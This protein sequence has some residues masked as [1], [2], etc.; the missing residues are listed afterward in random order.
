[1]RFSLRLNNDLAPDEFCTLAEVAEER[2]FD[3]LWVSND[4]FLH[5]ASVLLTAA[6][7]RT[8]TLSLGC[9]I[10]NPYTIHP[11]ELAMTAA[12]LQDVS[13]G[14]FLLGLAAGAGQFLE[15]VGITQHRPLGTTRAAIES[16]R[17]LTTGKPAEQDG[18]T[19]QAYLRI[20]SEG[21]PIY[22]GAM[23][24]KMLELAG[25]CAD[26]ALPLLYPPEHFP[27]ARDHIAVGLERGGRD[28]SSFD[29]PACIW[30]SVDTDRTAARDA[31]AAKIA[32][33]ASA[34]SP[35]LLA[36]AGLAPEDFSDIDAALAAHDPARAQSLV[37]ERMLRLGIAGDVDD[38][39]ARCRWLL[40]QGATH[41]SFGPPLGP[42]PRRAIELLG[43]EVLPALRD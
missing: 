2:G 38:V 35:Y 23:S 7:V 40:E 41:I 25:E 19:E 12:T 33:Y 5:S 34:F 31:L 21:V 27:T 15:W 29:L 1:M 39:V 26:G 6:A 9:G 42:D 3:Q 16:I 11:A 4:L 20:A 8:S 17:A 22:L 32:Y 43:E 24:P 14:R 13:S 18:W 36:R 37:D 30:C 10:F 28:A